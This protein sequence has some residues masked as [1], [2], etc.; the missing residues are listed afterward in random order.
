MACGDAAAPAPASAP[1]PTIATAP[2]VDHAA[3]R[4]LLERFQ[5][6]RC[7]DIPGV[8]AAP[9][10]QHCVN[11]HR[12]IV[13]GTFTAAPT[14]PG[15]L[16]RWGPHLTSLPAAPNLAAAARLRRTWVRDFLLRPVDVRPHLPATMPRLAITPDEAM[17]L[18]T[19]LVP[20]EHDTP[21]PA[22]DPAR[23]A[24]VFAARGCPAC[25]AP[26]APAPTG[27]APDAYLLAPDLRRV[28]ERL[29]PGLLVAWIVDPAH[30]VPGAAMP[31]LGLTVEEAQ[32]V[33]AHLLAAAG[34]VP[35]PPV[36]PRL[37]LL[38]RDVGYDEVERRVFR[39][40]CWHCHGA[41]HYAHG[42]GGPGNTG[43]F[44]FAPRGLELASY[45]GVASGSVGPD[46]KR[47]SIFAPLTDGTPRLIAHLLARQI[48]ER[49]ELAAVRGMPLGL[50][51]LPPADIQLVE[52]W[53][54][55]GRPE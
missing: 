2:V 32:D 28:A 47:R 20:I 6:A 12:E 8:A 1:V 46:G 49:G 44:G 26:D 55:Q 18:A 5:C 3:A 23:G 48:E 53:I 10:L 41:A 9:V 34:P 38:T 39:K 21:P 13:G 25:H 45:D 35:P 24:Q 15:D 29:Q 51:S 7:H 33:A 22:G 43:G 17:T 11:C 54:A 14:A 4:A 19:Y 37:P 40:I 36:P 30:V 27:R 31:T 52:S 50:P 42:D 16:T